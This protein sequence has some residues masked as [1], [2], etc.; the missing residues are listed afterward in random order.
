M[1]NLSGKCTLDQIK[2]ACDEGKICRVDTGNLISNTYAKTLSKK[3]GKKK[4]IVNENE[5]I[6]GPEDMVNDYLNVIS[7]RK[8]SK[9]IV[10]EIKSI[11]KLISKK[12]GETVIAIEEDLTKFTV[13]Q[14]RKLCKDEGVDECLSKTYISK[15]K[16]I[17]LIKSQRKKEKPKEKISPSIKKKEKVSKPILKKRLSPSKDCLDPTKDYDNICPDGKYCEVEVG[18][19]I[20]TN[21]DGMPIIQKKF[22]KK[23]GFDLYIDVKNKFLGKKDDILKI[24]ERQKGLK[25]KHVEK[26]IIQEE[27]PIKQD[28][29]PLVELEEKILPRMEIPLED[30]ERPPFKLCNTIDE[31]LQ[32]KDEE[33]CNAVFGD[34]EKDKSYK[35]YLFVDKPTER[36]FGGDDVK[37]LK[38]LQ[39]KLGGKIRKATC[40]N[41]KYP[42]KCGKNQVCDSDKDKCVGDSNIY[43]YNLIL[44]DRIIVS[45]NEDKITH[46]RDSLGGILKINEKIT[47]IRKESLEE[48]LKKSKKSLEEQI[49]KKISPS[50]IKKVSSIKKSKQEKIIEKPKIKSPLKIPEKEEIVQKIK[51]TEKAPILKI[52][53]KPP[54]MDPLYDIVEKCLAGL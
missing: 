40:G 2:Q 24:I 27:Q 29:P 12:T 35:Y 7:S 48:S 52:S 43:K 9:K 44:D 51:E 42:L 32:C 28:E 22:E 26:K 36:K 37:V 46:I 30:I 18:N 39:S 6:A 1:Q 34:C 41:K 10:S 11:K 19:C 16:L 54:E 14:L 21:N 8:I 3:P 4:I 31:Y 38:E 25:Q 49:I 5:C 50:L 17:S 20:A 45:N 13:P 33:I 53:E 47:P 23:Y 15:A